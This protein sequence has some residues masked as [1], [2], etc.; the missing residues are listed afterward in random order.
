[1][2]G[3][4]VCTEA[5][6]ESQLLEEESFNQAICATACCTI[7]IKHLVRS[8]VAKLILSGHRRPVR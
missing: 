1:M 7:M 4:A 2:D 3:P 5:D 6:A 8:L